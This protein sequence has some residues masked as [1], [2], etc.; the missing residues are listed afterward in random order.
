MTFYACCCRHVNSVNPAWNKWKNGMSWSR[1]SV[2]R[3]I[4]KLIKSN[5]VVTWSTLFCL[6]VTLPTWVH[7][8]VLTGPLVCP[9][10]EPTRF[11]CHQSISKQDNHN[12]TWRIYYM[13]F[14]CVESAAVGP[15][16]SPLP[17][18]PPAVFFWPWNV[19]CGTFPPFL[20]SILL[21]S[22]HPHQHVSGA[23]WVSINATMQHLVSRTWNAFF[24]D[25][26]LHS[27]HSSPSRCSPHS[28]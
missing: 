15:K 5:V 25:T 22:R 14:L 20:P 3:R 19:F 18:L 26:S 2:C 11:L 17:P 27:L 16:C 8:G 21:Q 10:C 9:D 4:S 6:S 1:I 7:Y 23:V 12:H 13:S 28:N 24:N